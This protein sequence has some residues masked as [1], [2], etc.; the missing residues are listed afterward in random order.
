MDLHYHRRRH[1]ALVQLQVGR[2]GN[3][4]AGECVDSEQLGL[5][6]IKFTQLEQAHE[7]EPIGLAQH[8]HRNMVATW[9]DDGTIKLWKP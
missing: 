2:Q 9:A 4:A 6:I 7:K 8:P 5:C 3:V 1:A